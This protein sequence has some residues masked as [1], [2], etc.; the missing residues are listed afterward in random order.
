[1]WPGVRR[2]SGAA[3]RRLE[4]GVVRIRQ[5]LL[6]AGGRLQLGP[7]KTDAGRRDL[8]LLGVARSALLQ[9]VELKVLG[10][11]SHEWTAHDLVFTTRTGHPVEP[12]NL[13]RSFHRITASHG[14]RRIP[15]HSLR[16]TTATLLKDLGVPPR[17]TMEILGHARI[18]VTMEIYTGADD[19]SRCAA[20]SKL[21]T[22]F[23][24]NPGLTDL[25]K[26][27]AV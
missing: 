5:Q 2:A 8:P 16:R 7:V 10:A 22:L 18:A 4:H 21:S 1:M 13:A 20:L 15:L 19:A 17:D 3:R 11:T 6:R 25:L 23:G 26:L 9:H 24:T 27:N 12:R 14:L